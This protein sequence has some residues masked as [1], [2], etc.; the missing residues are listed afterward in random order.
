M[1]RAGRRRGDVTN[2]VGLPP[3][4][5]ADPTQF[6]PGQARAAHPS[7]DDAVQPA[8]TRGAAAAAATSRSTDAVVDEPDN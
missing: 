3:E 5:D 4:A 1:V 6:A 7:F 2:C 8:A